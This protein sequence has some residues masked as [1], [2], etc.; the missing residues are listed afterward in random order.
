MPRKRNRSS[1]ASKISQTSH[2]RA[3]TERREL[4]GGAFEMPLRPEV[5]SSDVPLHLS[6]R[7][8]LELAPS[9]LSHVRSI[10]PTKLKQILNK[11]S[12]QKRY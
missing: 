1:R 6:K 12:Y 2:K 9:D 10:S 5:D 11:A 8:R 7:Q 4:Y 3:I